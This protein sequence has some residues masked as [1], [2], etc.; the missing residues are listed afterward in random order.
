MAAKAF[1][2]ILQKELFGSRENEQ[3]NKLRPTSPVRWRE[4]LL[5]LAHIHSHLDIH[6]PGIATIFNFDFALTVIVDVNVRR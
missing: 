4:N 6:L 1:L 3:Q 5:R 2:L